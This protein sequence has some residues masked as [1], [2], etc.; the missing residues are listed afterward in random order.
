MCISKLDILLYTPFNKGF[1]LCVCLS[2]CVCVCVCVCVSMCVC[3]RQ[4]R[5]HQMP[6]I[7]PHPRCLLASA[8][9]GISGMRPSPLK[10]QRISHIS[11]FFIASAPEAIIFTQLFF[12]AHFH[13]VYFLLVHSIEYREPSA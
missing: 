6:T 4:I 5:S 2:V 1:C 12:R 9:Q 7:S 8:H 3:V 10:S 13:S 11:C